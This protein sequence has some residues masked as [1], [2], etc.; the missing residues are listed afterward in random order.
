MKKIAI[1]ILCLA[2]LPILG[3]DRP[4]N[5]VYVVGVDIEP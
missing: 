2:L 4:K 1:L 3:C 5:G